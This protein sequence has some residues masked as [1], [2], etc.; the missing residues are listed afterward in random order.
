[1]QPS[2]LAFELIR[3]F[4]G[5]SANAIPSLLNRP[6]IGYG[7][8]VYPNGISVRVGDTCTKEQAEE[9]LEYEIN[10]KV[11]LLNKLLEGINLSQ[12]QFDAIVCFVQDMGVGNFEESGMFE[13]IKIDPTDEEIFSYREDD[14]GNPIADS[15]EFTKFCRIG[16]NTSPFMLRRRAAEADLYARK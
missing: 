9:W 13:R 11:K 5:F 7:T 14:K 4:D 12:H 10:A 8:I 15:C 2:K 1:M 6:S 16:K 3:Y